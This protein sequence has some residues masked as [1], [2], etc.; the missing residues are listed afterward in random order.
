MYGPVPVPPQRRPP[1]DRNVIVLRVVFVTLTLICFGALAWV[2]MLR[3]ALLRR[4]TSD[5][6]A[7]LGI[8]VLCTVCFGV[9][10]ELPEEDRRTDVAM[11]LLLMTA[12]GVTAHYLVVDIRHHQELAAGR[13]PGA[14]PMSFHPGMPAAR[15]YPP[16]PVNHGVTAGPG[17]AQGPTMPAYGFPQPQPQPQPHPQQPG[18]PRGPLRPPAGPAPGTP[19]QGG[20]AGSGGP[21]AE[22]YPATPTPGRPQP[23]RI[24]RVRAE[25]DELSD[26]LRKEEGG[27]A[28]EDGGGRR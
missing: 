9:V 12:V 20:P 25:L 14:G 4:K 15:P 23:R 13:P 1:A 26:L 16:G 17:A 18:P 19:P 24:D 21:A 8:L 3:I 6:L 28:G 5:W 7:F 11:V 2:P 22:P 27:G 10:G